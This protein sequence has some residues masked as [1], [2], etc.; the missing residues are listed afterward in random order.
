MPGLRGGVGP[1][2]DADLV[3]LLHMVRVECEA[4]AERAHAA[5]DA[6]AVSAVELEIVETMASGA[7]RLLSRF[8]LILLL[9][10]AEIVGSQSDP[11]TSSPLMVSEHGGF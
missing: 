9:H 1:V 7:H 8:A 6:D 10:G 2:T 5:F 11:D 4:R 3:D